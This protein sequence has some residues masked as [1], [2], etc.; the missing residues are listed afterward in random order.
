MGKVSSLIRTVTGKKRFSSAVILAAG[1]GTRFSDERAKQF[2]LICGKPVI[3]HSALAF[4]KCEL[5]DEIIVVCAV[6]E[7]E[8][9][10]SILKNGG[11]SKLTRIVVGGKTRGESAQNGFEAVNPACEFVAIH[12]AARCLVTPGMIEAAFESAFVCGGAACAAKCTDTLKRAD[13]AGNVLET[14][15]RE[16][17]WLVQT[18]QIFN[19]NMYRAALYYAEK[20]GVSATDDC[21]LCE[22]LGFKIK[23]VDSGKTNM[24]ITYPEDI[25]AAEAILTSRGKSEAEQ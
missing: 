23:M 18:P 10:R 24:K 4:E 16:S 15:D 2:E 20:D 11:I 5:V 17:I 7:T 25:V 19:A 1:R 8:K 14:V 6:N 13:G 21:A 22:R 12:D 9:C 3:L